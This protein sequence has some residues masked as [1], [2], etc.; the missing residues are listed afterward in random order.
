MRGARPV[1]VA[2]TAGA[3]ASIGLAQGSPPSSLRQE[4]ATGNL[5]RNADA[6]AG[7]GGGG[8]VVAIPEWEVG[9]NFTAVKYDA[10]GGYPTSTEAAP[11][12]GANFFAGGNNNAESSAHQFVDLGPYS[13]VIDAQRAEAIVSAWFGGFL[14]QN[15]S[16]TIDVFFRNE[17]GN[18]VG[19]MTLGPVS[20]ADREN[21]TKF[22]LRQTAKAVP[23]GTTHAIVRMLSTRTLGDSN[24]GYAD[25]LELRLAEKAPAAHPKPAPAFNK[26]L[27]HDAP[28]PGKTLDVQSPILPKAAKQVTLEAEL[29]GAAEGP[30][31]AVAPIPVAGLSEEQEL[32]I[33]C[34]E[35]ALDRL[36]ESEVVIGKFVGIYLACKKLLRP[37]ATSGAARAAQAGCRTRFVPV[38]RKGTRVTARQ[39]ARALART[40]ARVSI[41]CSASRTG[42]LS[43]LMVARRG[44]TL[45]RVLGTSRVRVAL[46]R[47]RRTGTDSADPT[48]VLRW[49]R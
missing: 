43:V 7:P 10:P 17:I 4:L 16:I 22:V 41:T 6:E 33:F 31:K 24:D 23:A 35:W 18:D 44:T 13:K 36:N 30:V 15:D 39:R 9:P 47:E 20:A 11:G 3:F 5:I 42:R 40:R 45:R 46:A 8:E 26:D 28:E 21:Q 29:K 49:N 12:G 14:G 1:V 38:R 19:Q 32:L 27:V 48:L 2:V 25:N 34:V 37:K